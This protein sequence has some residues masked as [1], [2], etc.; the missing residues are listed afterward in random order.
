MARLL[1]DEEVTLCAGIFP[2]A[3]WVG[4]E[5]TEQGSA[6]RVALSAAG[7]ADSGAEV[8][9]ERAVIRFGRSAAGGTDLAR[10]G[11][12]HPVLA[13]ELAEAG[14][15]VP[16]PLGPVQQTDV[17]PAMA[18]SFVPG[19]THPP[20]RGNPGE[21]A[22]GG[23]DLAVLTTALANLMM[24]LLR[25]PVQ[26][27][28]AQ[29]APIFSY[30]GPWTQAKVVTALGF[31]GEH[32]PELM[33]AA[34][35]VLAA[36]LSQPH[37]FGS[38]PGL[39]HGDLAGENMHWNDAFTTV[40]G[41]LDWDLASSWDPA[42]NLMHLSL[43]HGQQVVEPVAMVLGQRGLL[44]ADGID[45][46]ALFVARVRYWSGVWAAENLW[47]AA[48]RQCQATAGTVGVKPI[49]PAALRRL[50]AKLGPRLTAGAAAL[51]RLV[52]I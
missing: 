16:R 26:D 7:A 29:L 5:M 38:A 2:Q 34:S 25:V 33:A 52:A 42:I 17:G 12:L 24:A 46:P 27:T 1:T 30:R 3:V 20:V 48:D 39:V 14:I 47:H 22:H 45:S 40:T 31:V 11:R 50:F 15:A 9:A 13:A 18:F 6:Y 32:A 8:E 10:M 44:P 36:V 35:A 28:A 37:G 49:K 51:D 19:S 23:D 41:V 21:F 43:W 4:G